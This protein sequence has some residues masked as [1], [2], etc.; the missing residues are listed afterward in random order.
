MHIAFSPT[1]PRWILKPERRT[2]YTFTQEYRARK[3][4]P[5][6]I[7]IIFLSAFETPHGLEGLIIWE[8]LSTRSV[9]ERH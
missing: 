8:L 6:D 2:G 9:T 5:R 7:I 4:V 3:V 1:R